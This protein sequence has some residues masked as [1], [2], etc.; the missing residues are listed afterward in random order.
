MTKW[1]GDPASDDGLGKKKNIR[2]TT[3]VGRDL[4]EICSLVK[5][6]MAMFVS[7]F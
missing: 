2:Q 3:S 5:Y 4:K 6:I 1:A 7:G